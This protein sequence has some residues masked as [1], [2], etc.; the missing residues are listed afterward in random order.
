MLKWCEIECA[1]FDR[2]PIAFPCACAVR[3]AFDTFELAL[4]YAVNDACVPERS[5]FAVL[6]THPYCD[7]TRLRCLM[8]K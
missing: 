7:V 4:R 6:E 5:L 3:V 2:Y 1:I 8:D